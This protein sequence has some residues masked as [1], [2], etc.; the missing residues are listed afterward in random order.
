MGWNSYFDAPL[1]QALLTSAGI[2]AID[3]PVTL[4]S[5][6]ALTIVNS[7]STQTPVMN[8]SAY[9]SLSFSSTETGSNPTVLC[10]NI[11]LNWYED[12]A[13]TI[14]IWSEQWWVPA[15]GGN[16]FTLDNV[17]GPYLQI[18]WSAITLVGNTSLNVQ[19]IASY[20]TVTRP[21]SFV[22]STLLSSLGAAG[23]N[24]EQGIV[25][26]VLT[27]PVGASTWGYFVTWMGPATLSL[28]LPASTNFVLQDLQTGTQYYSTNVGAGTLATP[29]VTDL[30]IGRGLLQITANNSGGAP[31]LMRISLSMN[32]GF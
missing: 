5:Q 15:Y 3:N 31:S 32:Q 11:T 30:L 21:Q 12:A 13:G 14:L 16:L 22:K 24:G 19:V 10:R 26:A 23:Q 17:K 28:S 4:Y 27:L 20:R 1:L 25:T 9:Q 29:T 8:I 6:S 2:P 7:T 18:V